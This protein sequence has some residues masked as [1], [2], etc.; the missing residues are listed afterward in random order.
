MKIYDLDTI[1][2]DRRI[3]TTR[4]IAF[5]RS[6]VFQAFRDPLV[7]AKWWG[8]SG[9]TNTFYEFDFRE[10]GAWRFTMHSPDGKDFPNESCFLKINE[11]S[12]IVFDH[13]CA[14]Y[15]QAHLYFDE[16]P[17]GCR[18]RWY[19]VFEDAQLCQNVAKIAQD[20]NEQNLDRLVAALG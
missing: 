12:V 5:Q 17:A 9:F 10:G 7:L 1:P 16:S 18:I 19:M 14:P 20:A 8:P 4:V 13:V 6:Q 11:P 3:D 2:S 15:F